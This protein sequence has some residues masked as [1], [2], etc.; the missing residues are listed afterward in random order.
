MS[1][2]FYN[3]HDI[4]KGWNHVLSPKIRLLEI[5]DLEKECLQAIVK[6]KQVFIYK[7]GGKGLPAALR[8]Q[9]GFTPSNEQLVQS[10]K[11]LQSK[12]Y[13]QILDKDVE[14]NKT[15][16]HFQPNEMKIKEDA[17]PPFEGGL[18]PDFA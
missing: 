2:N 9:L 16:I 1:K 6:F 12:G 15:T 3:K 14:G 10:F 18:I 8:P 7:G 17:E 4:K 5:S 13:C 11:V